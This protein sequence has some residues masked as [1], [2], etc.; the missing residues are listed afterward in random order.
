[1]TSAPKQPSLQ[2]ISPLVPNME[3]VALLLKTG[4]TSGRLS[5]FGVLEQRL[6]EY[7]A[8]ALGLGDNRRVLMTSSGHTALMT[9][10]AALG[11]RRAIIPAFTFEST[12]S[13]LV[14]QGIDVTCVD[15]DAQT[16]CL[17]VEQLA[18]CGDD[19]DTV[20][21]VAALSTIPDLDALAAFCRDRKKKLI[22]DGAA[23][24]GTPIAEYGDAYC[25]SFHATKTFPMGEGGAVVV[26]T[27]A[28][29][30]ARAFINFGL[31]PDRERVPAL[32][33][34][35]NGK[36]SEYTAAVGLALCDHVQTEIRARIRNTQRYDLRLGDLIPPSAASSLTVYAFLPLFLPSADRAAAVTCALAA[37]AI[38]SFRYYQPVRSRPNADRLYAR[39]VCLP[40]HSRLTP[41][42][43][44]SIIAVVEGAL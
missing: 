29:D 15:V 30:R 2:F 43:I 41:S 21:A 12:Q 38:P 19:Y 24:W 5:N 1:M 16:G 11:V 36:M 31:G 20:V 6:T 32:E 34:G 7:V 40:V 25:Y 17:T 44:E 10:A 27:D 3:H 4:F 39:S 14:G 13:A 37:A 35:I 22:V 8:T 9:A 18:A 42:D 23:T 28:Y 26:R 33:F